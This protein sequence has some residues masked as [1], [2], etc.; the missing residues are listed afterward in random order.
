MHPLLTSILL[1]ALVLTGTSY[2]ST[3]NYPACLI[4]KRTAEATNAACDNN[5]EQTCSVVAQQQR[6]IVLGDVHGEATGM[7]ELL[8]AANVTVRG[9][10]QGCRWTD[11]NE[12]GTIL[13][14]VGDMVDRGAEAHEA[15]L[16]LEELHDTATGKNQV[17]RLLGNHDIW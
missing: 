6:L 4:A 17:V 3:A 10:S 11:Q 16:C 1:S 14:Q 5:D 9:D 13:I 15:W 7:R 12:A 8:D 2:S